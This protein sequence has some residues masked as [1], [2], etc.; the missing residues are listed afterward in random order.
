MVTSSC[1]KFIGRKIEI[2]NH[3]YSI[4]NYALI[5]FQFSFDQLFQDGFFILNITKSEIL[6]HDQRLDHALKNINKVLNISPRNY[7]A[8]IIK[9]KIL[10]AK[11]ETIQAEEILRDLLITK[12]NDP[13]LWLQLSE[14]QRAGKNIIGYH[15]S[16][17]E[18]LMLLG[19]FENALNQFRFALGLSNNSFQI[20]ETI[21]T[22]INLA[23]K[24]LGTRRGF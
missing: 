7:P 21:M 13:S 1:R 23:Q 16:R 20:S 8:S 22:K 12:N 2:N 15:L 11:K 6:F 17:G 14:V 18:Y 9:S 4:I 5:F 24:K 19:D 10:S 3:L